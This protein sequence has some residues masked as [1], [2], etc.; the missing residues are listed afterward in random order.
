MHL[1]LFLILSKLTDK[2]QYERIIARE[3]LAR[4]EA[5]RIMEDKSRELYAANQRLNSLNFNLEKE[6]KKRTVKIQE[7]EAQ[8]NVLF[9]E[10]PFPI[11]VY[12]LLDFKIIAVNKTALVKYQFSKTEFLE[13]KIIDLHPT[14]ELK[15][16]KDHLK[17]IEKYDGLTQE[18]KHINAF[19]NTFDVIVKGSSIIYNNRKARLAVVEDITQKKKAQKDREE[20]SKKYQDL[21][22]SS[23][24][25]IYRINNEG[26]FTYVNPTAIKL[27][28]FTSEELLSM[29]FTDL[30]TPKYKQ[31]VIN[32]YKFQLENNI[33]TT[34]TEFPIRIKDGREI[35]L[36]QNVEPSGYNLNGVLIFNATAR[37]ITD[38]KKLEKALLR[39]EEKYRSIIEN[40][41]LGLMEVDP[42]GVIIKAYP[43]FC[44][45]SGYKAEELEGQKG[46]LFLLDEEGREFYKKQ[47]ADRSL[48]KSNVY[49]IQLLRKDGTKRWVLVSGAP[50]YD[51]Y[52]RVKG[53]FGIHLDIT[54]R[55]ELESELKIAK[56]KAEDSLK[57]KELFLANISHEI[58]TPLNAIIGIAELMNLSTTEPESI[59]KLNHIGQAGKGL[60]SIINELLL[61]SKMDAY[62]EKLELKETNLHS[63]LTQN[64]ELFENQVH[65]K[66]ISY[67]AE[68]NINQSTIYWLDPVKLGQ[69]IQNILSNAIKFTDQGEVKL[70][71]NI[72]N[73]SYDNDVIQFII[74]DTGI[75]IPTE[76]ID[77]I[78]DVF[79]QASNNVSGTF[80]GTGLGLPIVKKLLELMEGEINVISEN[81]TTSFEFFLNLKR[82]INSGTKDSLNIN[83]GSFK[84][85]KGV[86]V[87][88]AE[89]NKV[90][91]FLIE[92]YLKHLN[93]EFTIVNNG[94]EAISCLKTNKFDA[95]LM[96]MRMPIM[97]GLEATK[98]IRDDL[99]MKNLPILAL[100]AN[101][102]H[103]HKKEC[104]DAGMND[105]LAKP[106]NISQL[107]NILIKNLNLESKDSILS[108][109]RHDE[110]NL[111]DSFQQ[112]LD[113][114]FIED[115][116]V[117]IIKLEKAASANNIQ[118]LK[119]ICHSMRPSLLHLKQAEIIE[120]TDQIEFGTSDI[121]GN[122]YELISK[123]KELTHRMKS[124]L[125]DIPI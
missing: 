120:I 41:E 95:V 121:L 124:D 71:A 112:K 8:L 37:D 51:E 44:E 117:R 88:V 2:E 102:Y 13:K 9:D 108:P 42:D 118:M 3:R 50:F 18:W 43:K 31:Q 107:Q 82:S 4:K 39:S 10:H 7:S 34:Y 14:H 94:E 22:E 5:E 38:R 96:D 30:V 29:S 119:D 83:K 104:K 28:G 58:R 106:F 66:P 81:G 78:F 123:L 122:T 11:I 64:F 53:S 26:I 86:K 57:S 116:E 54:E 23:S 21:I 87:L 20:Q 65:H 55:K 77:T 70:S 25:I 101:A 32:F 110:V 90:N 109:S 36:G 93:V 6:V 99:G 100:T 59:K 52:N 17:S 46:A 98:M 12:D 103:T 47:L 75:G 115:T 84:D 97:N 15:K 61:L 91:Q 60:L 111:P 63:F 105:S 62:K 49:E 114:I 89:D 125:T 45:L 80:G 73:N 92:G 56:E 35:W 68:I 113:R 48:G 24:D 40:M 33:E 69:V 19:G 76:N 79:E 74:S 16:L 72:L 27:S 1:K 85:F 67:K